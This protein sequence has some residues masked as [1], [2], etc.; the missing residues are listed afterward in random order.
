MD[1]W[2]HDRPRQKFRELRKAAG[3][4]ASDDVEAIGNMLRSLRERTEEHLGHTIPSA[5]LTVPHLLALYDEDVRD[6][7]E[8]IGLR[9]TA[10]PYV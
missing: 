9:Y 1:E 7:F 6:A 4:P 10:A 2:L 8:W 3:L 5:L